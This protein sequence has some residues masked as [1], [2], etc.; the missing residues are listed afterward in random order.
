[1]GGIDLNENDF[2]NESQRYFDEMMKLYAKN[3][4]TTSNT[5]E[6]QPAPVLRSENITPVNKNDMED[7]SKNT[8]F[9]SRSDEM[10]EMPDN[11]QMGMG[12]QNNAMREMPERNNVES[13]TRNMQQI[14]ENEQN[15][16]LEENANR[17]NSTN[18][19]NRF[20]APVIPDFIRESVSQNADNS[21]R[22]ADISSFRTSPT[23][24]KPVNNEYGFLKVEVRTGEN[25]IP[26]PGAAVTV[27]VKN[28]E[29][30]EIVFT[31]ITD[32]SGSVPTIKLPAPPMG[33]G[34]TPDSFKN[35]STYAVSA[36]MKGFYRGISQNVPVF[37]GI[38]SIQR[39]NLIPEPFNFDDMGRSIVN[40][41]TE[42]NF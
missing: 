28:G 6:D 37:S 15:S 7:L 16:P 12:M 42:P 27:E 9:N 35:Y 18:F 2:K 8:E 40:E 1:M 25:G 29:K 13:Q 19:E 41:N 30:G 31:G 21:K 32:N 34:K 39:F 33:N 24:F 38:T 26:V 10:R 22:E 20:P 17:E 11:N 14:H 3:G 36:Y 23:A 4:N 5:T